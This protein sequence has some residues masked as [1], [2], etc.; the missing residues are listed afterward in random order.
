[1]KHRKLTPHEIRVVAAAA[2]VQDKTV[3]RYLNQKPGHTSTRIA[4][5]RELARLFPEQLQHSKAS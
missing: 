1:M 2:G 3:V 5:E 4:I